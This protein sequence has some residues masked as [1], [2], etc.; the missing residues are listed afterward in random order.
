ML[1]RNFVSGKHDKKDGFHP[2]DESD[3]SVKL[4]AENSTV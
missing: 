3:D 2:H 4:G 1:P